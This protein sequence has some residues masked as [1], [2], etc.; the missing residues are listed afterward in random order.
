[1]GV[2]RRVRMVRIAVGSL[3]VLAAALCVTLAAE[4]APAF[5]RQS[6]F[7]EF[8]QGTLGNGGANLY[9]SR[10][11]RV[12]VINK[13]DLNRDGFVDVLFS[14][15]HDVLSGTDAFIYWGSHNYTSLLPALWKERPL[16][17]VALGLAD[18]NAAVTRLPAF[19]G[20]RSVIADL[21]RDG[22][23]EIVFCNYIHN[24]P[25]VRSAFVYWGGRDGYSVQR[26]TE[27]PTSW[28]AGVA[29]I[30]LNGD[31]FPELVFANEGVEAGAEEIS[32]EGDYDSFIYWG[33]ATGFDA[34]HP[35]RLPTRGAVDAAAG[36]FDGDGH[37]DLAFLNNSPK[38]KELQIFF[39]GSPAFRDAR[40]QVLPVEAATS[41]RAGD[42]NA[43]GRADLVVTTSS[44]RFFFE[45][46]AGKKAPQ[47]AAEI[48][49]GGPDG[50]D[51]T[52]TVRLPTY[53]ARD[54][55]IQDLNGD[56]WAD[57][58]FANASDGATPEV[59]S[60]VYA[61]SK[62]GFSADRRT[63]L[64]T[65][66]AAGV[67]AADLNGD[68]HPDL[69]FANSNNRE[70]YD[71]PSYIYWGSASGYAPYMR[72]DLQSFGAV[73]VNTADLDRDG[74]LDVLLVNQYSGKVGGVSS[75]IFWG[76]PHHYYS[77]A[78]MTSLAGEGSYGTATADLNGD[79]WPDLV[80]TNSYIDVA[81]L[82]WGGA[83]G[84]SPQRRQELP[85]PRS[86]TCSVADLNKDGYLDLVFTNQ[87]DDRHVGTILWGSKDGYSETGRTV[88][89][90]GNRRS[91]SNVVADLNRDGYLDLVFPDE[92]FGELQIW[93]GSADGYSP[94]RTWLAPVSAGAV[95]LADL[96][97]DGHLDFVV[98]GSFDPK[99]KSYDT[100]TRIFWGTPGGTPSF[101]HV[102][103]LEAH[104]AIECAISDLNR[105]GQL[106]LVLS[107]YM[108]DTTRSLP[109]YIYWGRKG[110]VYSNSNRTDLP[111]ESSAG[112]QTVDLNQDGYPDIVIHNHLKDGDHA[113]N[114]YIYWN[115]PQGFDPARRTELPNFGPHASQMVDAG[116]LYTRRL[117]EQYES[118]PLEV[119]PGRRVGG[120]AWTGDL[121]RRTALKLQ[122]RTAATRAGLSKATWTG[123]AGKG[124]FF[125]R[126]TPQLQP[127]AGSPR[128]I[129]YRVT[130]TSSDGGDWPVLA[131]VTLALQ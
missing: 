21:N 102:V 6:T 125:D 45:Q 60:F 101:A 107:N 57:L 22:Y 130:F 86:W 62:D 110:G 4:S 73:S 40:S 10:E 106:D 126:P 65:L 55:W 28:A 123:A 103:N 94:S 63:E 19:G 58:V 34:M 7:G 35:G 13:R 116:H 66:G 87:V 69:I 109:L 114:S 115:G 119:P 3:A 56:G 51:A 59:N 92:Y 131:D 127:F 18:G 82:Y 27:L 77:T 23:P 41:V 97:G 20:G 84:F 64:P 105:D 118:A 25:G 100:Q 98:T 8:M 14:A 44:T 71:V 53:S 48:F 76:N 99:K 47:Q 33:S 36:D 129:Q 5:I 120:L 113:I 38:A 128:W 70:T 1:V 54:S 68:G 95:K 32:P 88:L 108:S 26:R 67:T 46:A 24:Y 72:S 122:L 15:G 91:L 96:N 11:G 81:Y 90:L 75:H 93:W 16:A 39:G 85:A 52:R 124:S 83:D 49:C 17:Q 43:D 9:V 89:Q 12:E 30:D 111:A 37:V 121:P 117:E 42:L 112:V 79:G 2:A 80:I 74:K 61:G 104:G 50:F 29:A 78:L 31:G